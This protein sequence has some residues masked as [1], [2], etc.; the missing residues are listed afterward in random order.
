MTQNTTNA[1]KNNARTMIRVHEKVR[2]Q[3]MSLSLGTTTVLTR[4]LDDVKLQISRR[5]HKDGHGGDWTRTSDP[6][7]MNPL[8]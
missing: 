7:L 6:G 5:A 4:P 8:L 2:N 1:A 3:S